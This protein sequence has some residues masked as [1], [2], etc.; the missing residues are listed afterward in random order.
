[1]FVAAFE[2]A[3]LPTSLDQARAST[4]A[5]KQSHSSGDNR[6]QDNQRHSRHSHARA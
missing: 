6:I 3:A 4:S 2:M 1:V 5:R